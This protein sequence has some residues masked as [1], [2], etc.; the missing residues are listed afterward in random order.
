MAWFSGDTHPHGP[1]TTRRSFG[2]RSLIEVLAWWSI[3]EHQAIHRGTFA[4]VRELITAIYN[5]TNGWNQRAQ[6]FV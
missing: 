5:F 1:G 3:I 4:S 6:L 2:I